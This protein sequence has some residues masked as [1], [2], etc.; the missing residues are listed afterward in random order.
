MT[1]LSFSGK[2]FLDRRTRARLRELVPAMVEEG[3]RAG[4]VHVVFVDDD[5]I[6]GLHRDHFGDPRPTD[7][8]TF[9]IDDDADQSARGSA[10]SAILGEI[11]VSA[12]TAQREAA[13]RGLSPD[14]EAALY[15]IHGVL[16][17]LG[18]DD[19]TPEARREMRRAEKK[20]LVRLRL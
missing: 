7:V 9:P 16:H 5:T 8:I 19:T 11:V 20:Y 6:A 15:V 12:D 10:V 18:Y 17:L 2:R 4:D 13:R 14:R 1:S 3:G